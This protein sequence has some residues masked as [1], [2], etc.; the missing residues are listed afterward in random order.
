M[1]KEKRGG[2]L[3]LRLYLLA[4]PGIQVEGREVCADFGSELLR[5]GQ[6]L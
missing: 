6:N 5:F 3:G 4:V 1:K 2:L